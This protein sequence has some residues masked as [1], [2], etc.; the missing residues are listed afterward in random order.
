[1]RLLLGCEVSELNYSSALRRALVIKYFFSL[2]ANFAKWKYLEQESPLP[3]EIEAE[4]QNLA[5]FGLRQ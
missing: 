4:D 2:D 1:M 3:L 5:I